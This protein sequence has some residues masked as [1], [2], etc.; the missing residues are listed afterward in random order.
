MNY[1]C[2]VCKSPNDFRDYIYIGNNSNYI[3]DT[4]DYTSQL[5]PIRDQ[6]YQGTCYAQ[7]AACVKEWQEK[8]DYGL[9]EYLSPQFFYNCR[10]NKYDNNTKNDEGMYGRDVMKL[11][12][13]IGICTE[14][15][16][17]YGLIEHKDKIS[18]NAFKEAKR[19]IIKGYA[20]IDTIL[21]LKKNLYENGPCLIAFPVYNYGKEFWKK[22]GPKIGGHAVTIVGYN[23]DGFI[24]RN[25]WGT[26]W[27]DK[28]YSIYKYSDWGC[29]WEIWTTIDDKTNYKK[30]QLPLNDEEKEKKNNLK[31][32]KCCLIL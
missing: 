22:I 1:I 25:S 3:P 32:N 5:N 2:N 31:K 29:H 15:R 8:K 14:F 24:I 10:P 20:K 17:P 23:N 18:E 4:L 28:G 12:K 9:N 7:T 11:L 6:G 19:H 21:N 26:T 27:G 30:E 13:N 16:Y